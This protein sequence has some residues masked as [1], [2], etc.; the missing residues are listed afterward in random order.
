M[1]TQGRRYTSSWAIEE[2]IQ[3]YRITED[4]QVASSPPMKNEIR[5]KNKT[6]TLEEMG[7]TKKT[8]ERSRTSSPTW[9]PNLVTASF[10]DA[11]MAPRFT[12]NKAKATGIGASSFLDLKAELA[13]KEKE[14]AENKAAGKK[15]TS[16]GQ[17]PGKVSVPP[18]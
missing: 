3:S 15:S 11:W 17:K 2:I 12:T 5:H 1:Q 9:L 14:I 6:A 16:G 7:R 10:D 18:I 13:A 4:C 8:E